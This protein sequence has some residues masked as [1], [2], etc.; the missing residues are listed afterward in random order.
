MQEKRN[1]LITER[2]RVDEEIKVIEEKL[3]QA[4]LKREHIE[5]DIHLFDAEIEKARKQYKP[6][7]NKYEQ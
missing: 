5:D 6:Q 4:K 3:N 2:E 1:E 7:L